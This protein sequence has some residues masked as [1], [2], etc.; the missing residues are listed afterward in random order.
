MNRCLR[1]QPQ[2]HRT[3]A[4]AGIVYGANRDCTGTLGVVDEAD[5]PRPTPVRRP[6][7]T[8]GREYGSGL[9]HRRILGVEVLKRTVSRQLS[10]HT[11]HLRR[12]GPQSDS[13][14]QTTRTRCFRARSSRRSRGRTMASLTVWHPTWFSGSVACGEI[15][16]ASCSA[17]SVLLDVSV[18]MVN[19]VHLSGKVQGVG[20]PAGIGQPSRQAASEAKQRRVLGGAGRKQDRAAVRRLVSRVEAFASTA[21]AL[22]E[23]PS[24]DASRDRRRRY[25]VVRGQEVGNESTVPSV[26]E[27]SAGAKSCEFTDLEHDASHRSLPV[28]HNPAAALHIDVIRA[29]KLF[30]HRTALTHRSVDVRDF[31]D[32]ERKIGQGIPRRQGDFDSDGVHPRRWATTQFP[33]PRLRGSPRASSSETPDPHCPDAPSF[34]EGPPKKTNLA[35]RVQ[36]GLNPCPQCRRFGRGHRDS[37]HNGSVRKRSPLHQR[38]QVALILARKARDEIRFEAA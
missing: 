34:M 38:R 21:R 9:S 31:L 12:K 26:V 15:F 35:S 14:R 16:V 28:S 22:V 32:A 2:R 1:I 36:L 20:R 30:R 8:N 7:W 37:A 17:P 6:R 13:L 3:K 10:A 24:F 27:Q 11:S 25:A 29:L 33:L 18:G 19:A 4:F 5:E 23:P